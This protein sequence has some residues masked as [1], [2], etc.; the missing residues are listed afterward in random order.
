MTTETIIAVSII[1]AALL[2]GAIIFI[3]F[4]FGFIISYQP[5]KKAKDGQIRVACVGDSITYGFMV[6]NRRK[7]SYPAVLNALLGENY[8]VNN[9]AYTN[10]TAIKSADYPLVNEKIYKKSLEFKPQIVLIMLGSNDT[11]QVNWNEQRFVND[12]G[13]IVDDY[14]SQ[15]CPPKVYLLLPPPL[16]EVHGKV[17][18]SLR[19]TVVENEIIPALKRIASAKGLAYIDAYSVFEGKK[20][21]FVDGVH[22][23]VAGSRL[24]AET[25]HNFLMSE[26]K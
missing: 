3:L 13:E 5:V 8:C 18:Y 21:L 19:Q 1:A 7:N 12:Y 9:F 20:K 11:K 16:F 15:E 4:H 23:N 17:P 2:A 22:P 24:L 6:R 10:R 25:V 26:N 14:L